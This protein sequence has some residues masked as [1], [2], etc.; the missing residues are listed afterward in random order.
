[1]WDY[2]VQLRREF[3]TNTPCS[4]GGQEAFGSASGQIIGPIDTAIPAVQAQALQV[5]AIIAL[6][7]VVWLR[8]EMVSS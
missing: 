3:C 6:Q 8:D 5:A 1:M 7:S 2:T 4:T